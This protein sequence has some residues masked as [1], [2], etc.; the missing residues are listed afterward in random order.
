[1]HSVKH[2]PV[3]INRSACLVWKQ[4]VN[5]MTIQCDKDICSGLG[6]KFHEISSTLIKK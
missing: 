4:D 2:F 5:M 3:I 1:M 6:R